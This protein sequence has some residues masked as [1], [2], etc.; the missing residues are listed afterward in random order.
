MN[1]FRKVLY[2]ILIVLTGFLGIGAILGGI[3]LMT[4][5]YAPPLEMLTGSIFPSFF[6]PGLALTALVGGS[7]LA[8]MILLIRKHPFGVLIALTAGIIIMF[9]E[10]IEVLVIGMQAGPSQFMQVFYFMLGTLI[11]VFAVG[12]CGIDLLQE[13]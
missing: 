11:C 10:F 5:F 8:A 4:S 1:K 7:G 12:I 9:F 2:V 3:A 6:L 13:K